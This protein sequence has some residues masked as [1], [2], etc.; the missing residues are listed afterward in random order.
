MPAFEIDFGN[1]SSTHGHGSAAMD[2]MD[3][4]RAQVASCIGCRARDVV[5][6]SGAT[7]ANNMA[8]SGLD[9][10]GRGILVGATEHSSVLEPARSVKE[11]SVGYV[12]V[13]P[14]GV[15]DLDG[16]ERMLDDD[17][18]LV[19]IMAANSET[20]V[21][22]PVAE[23]ARIVHECGALFHCDAVQ[24]IGKIPFGMD[25][26]CVDMVTL[27][28][29]KIYGPKG[30][31]AIA[32]TREARGMLRPIIHGG[33]QE[34]GMR[35]GTPNVPAIVGFGIACDIAAAEGLADM[36]KQAA[37]RD[38]FEEG[39][40]RKA[41][42]VIVNGGGAKR[43][44]NTSNIRIRGALA[45]AVMVGAR[46]VEVSTGSAC[47]SSAIEPSHV[48]TAMGLDRDAAGESIRVSLG[49]P[50]KE[51]DID[52]AVSGLASASRFVRGKMAGGVAL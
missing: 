14:D 33:G 5:F 42:D 50:T 21:I 28:S 34:E 30:C 27:S 52:A 46:G 9:T 32:A 18:G 45:D 48:L 40:E 12:P 35:S 24:A 13:G 38:M 51:R 29:H 26:L 39:M 10:G 25:G 6:T 37:L 3:A 4:A 20:G 47:S 41:G 15:T 1:P 44:P 8:V 36:P 7:E 31:G 11:K 49:R 16:L 23:I 17:V 2:M 43:L 19:S 22:Q